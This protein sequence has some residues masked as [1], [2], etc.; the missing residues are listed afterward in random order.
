MT[1]YARSD[2]LINSRAS[3]LKTSSEMKIG[4]SNSSRRHEHQQWLLR[5]RAKEL[6]RRNRFKRRRIRGAQTHTHLHVNTLTKSSVKSQKDKRIVIVLPSRLDFEE[7]YETTTSHFAIL[8]EAVQTGLRIKTLEFGKIRAISPSAALV[9]A[10]EVDQWKQ[11]WRGKLR[12]DLPTWDEDIK[13]LLCQMGYFEL[14]DIPNPETDWPTKSMT[15]LPFK[16]GRVSDS[17]GGQLAKELRIHIE[18]LV[19]QKIKRH[20][21][22]EG[23]SEAITNVVQHA[24]CGVTDLSRKQWWLSASFDS[25]AQKLC[26]TFYDQGVGIPET[27]PTSGFSEQIKDWTNT[28]T[29]SRKIEAAMAVGRTA[30][31][32]PERGKGLQNLVEFARSHREGSL[33]IFS[34]LGMYRQSFTNG[35][36]GQRDRDMRR[37][38]KNS[39]GG[40]LIEWSVTI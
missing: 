16:R 1:T 21:L 40:T 5:R 17:N 32:L 9:L 3:R 37:D 31:Q 33:A 28:W 14:L 19:K 20:F 35:A 15:F 29:D 12:A 30:S 13:R 18:T 10:S 8:R 22:F 25:D 11:R 7:N 24:Y 23:L 36:D 39:V 34:N 27:L 38:H 26:V 4:T 2:S 6:W